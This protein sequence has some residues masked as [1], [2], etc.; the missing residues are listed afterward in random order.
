[1]KTGVPVRVPLGKEELSAYSG[2]GNL[3]VCGH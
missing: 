1:M 3:C 2:S